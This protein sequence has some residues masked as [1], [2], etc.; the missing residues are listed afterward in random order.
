MSVRVKIW[1]DTA[2]IEF[3]PTYLSE[4]KYVELPTADD[5]DAEEFLAARAVFEQA[6]AKFIMLLHPPEPL[7]NEE[8]AL[9]KKDEVI[10]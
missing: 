3:N 1:A 4:K 10:A 6:R 8:R 5:V 2:E 7:S 9:L